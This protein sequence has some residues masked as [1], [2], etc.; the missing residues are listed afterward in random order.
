MLVSGEVTEVQ[1]RYRRSRMRV[2][3]VVLSSVFNGATKCIVR[4][5][6]LDKTTRS[7]AVEMTWRI[8]IVRGAWES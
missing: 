6:Q 1:Q 8:M 4:C 7:P 5:A 2:V 3:V